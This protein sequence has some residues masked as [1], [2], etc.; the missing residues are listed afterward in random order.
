MRSAFSYHRVGA[1]FLTLSC[2]SPAGAADPTPGPSLRIS[3]T[4]EVGDIVSP[5][6]QIIFAWAPDPEL[7]PDPNGVVLDNDGTTVPGLW[8][9]GL[10]TTRFVPDEPWTPGQLYTIDAGVAS[11]AFTVADV[12]MPAPVPPIL[13][14]RKRQ[15]KSLA[16]GEDGA[17]GL[18]LVRYGATATPPRPYRLDSAIVD[19]VFVGGEVTIEQR[20]SGQPLFV[21]A[22]RVSAT[23]EVS[24]WTTSPG[25]TP[26][27]GG[28][29]LAFFL[30]PGLG[31]LFARRP[32]ADSRN[33]RS[34][35]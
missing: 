4:P 9:R 18:T 11:T 20:P 34:L 7:D 1:L 33:A 10:S 2:L 21:H 22:V 19:D 17:P 15:K 32:Y 16:F 35:W 24:S 26:G 13:S 28:S 8:I 25:F 3:V 5:D 6:V 30:V 31:L 12:G 29:S 14:E 23:G 27:C